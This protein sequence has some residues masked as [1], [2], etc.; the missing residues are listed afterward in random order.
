MLSLPDYKPDYQPD[1]CPVNAAQAVR[2]APA[3]EYFTRVTFNISQG[4]GALIRV[5][6]QLGGHHRHVERVGVRGIRGFVLGSLRQVQLKHHLHH[7]ILA[8]V[9][10]VYLRALQHAAVRRA[11]S[12]A[13][14]YTRAVSPTQPASIAILTSPYHVEERWLLRSMLACN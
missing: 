3:A 9:V 5:H 4:L 14:L 12:V 7:K 1:N 8:S 10:L 6:L 2:R 11:R 13:V